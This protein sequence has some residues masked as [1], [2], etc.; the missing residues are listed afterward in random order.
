MCETFDHP[1]QLM[2]QEVA[3]PNRGENDVLIDIAATGLGYVDALMVSG[4]Y[5]IKPNLPFIPGIEIAG[6]VVGPGSAGKSLKAG[7]HVFDRPSRG[8][9]AEQAAVREPA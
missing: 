9:L 8:C 7:D 6:T 5:Q 1:K 3:A 4:R 2:V